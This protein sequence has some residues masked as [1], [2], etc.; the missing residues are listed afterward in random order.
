MARLPG[1]M[2]LRAV[3]AVAACLALIAVPAPGVAARLGAPAVEPHAMAE[4]ALATDAQ[5]IPDGSR[6]VPLPSGAPVQL[7]FTLAFSNQTELASLLQD[8]GDPGSA[9]YRHYLTYPEF[10]AQFGPSP[11]TTDGL[12]QYLADAGAWGVTTVAGGLGVEATLSTTEA[13][14]LLGVHFVRFAAPTGAMGTTVEGVPTLPPSLRSS[15]VGVDGLSGGTGGSLL[16]RTLTVGSVQPAYVQDGSFGPDWYLGSDFTQAYGAISLLPGNRTSVPNAV[17]PYRVA[18]ATLLA[19]G[20]NATTA[21]TLPPFDPSVLNDYFNATFPSAWPHPNVTGVPVQPLGTPMPPL[22]GS[23]GGQNDSTGFEIEN[24]LDLEMAGSL[25]PGAALYNF[26]FSGELAENPATWSNLPAYLTD[27]FTSALAY[28]YSPA[29]LAVISCSFG[30]DDLNFSLW[31][32]DLS[33]AAAMGVTVV[34]SSGDQGNA[35]SQLTGRSQDPWPLW[36]ASAAFSTSG[37]VAVGG[38]SLELSGT[39]TETYVSGPL[40]LSYDPD[41]DGIANSSAW[42]DTSG[43]PGDYAGTEGGVSSVY[44][45]PT[46]QFHSAAQPEI[47]NAAE[48]EGATALGRAEPDVAFP[49]NSTIAFVAAAANETPYYTVLAGT[50]VAAP[51]LA[52]LLADVVAVE[53][54][55]GLRFGLGYLDPVLYNIS[56]YYQANPTSLSSPFVPVDFGSNFV[57]SAGPGWNPT[58]GWGGLNAPLFLLADENASIAGYRY[59]GPTPLLPGTTPTPTSPETLLVVLAA[60]VLVVVAAA[61]VLARRARPGPAAGAAVRGYSA[62][63]SKPGSPAPYATFACPSC[64]ADR[65]AEPGHCPHCGAM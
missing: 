49:A 2:V 8:V 22:P 34:A 44:P 35:P 51:V 27:D 48:L 17:F 12:E 13:G 38:V 25:A 43:G 52:G 65:P 3:I 45:E 19:S 15:V 56:S 41:V 7:T 20:Y 16:A 60:A 47:V 10:M 29:R 55:S 42:W 46:W 61:A 1:G 37:A 53:Q 5:T 4:T 18:V 31:D 11:A 54:A 39:A 57:F 24:S 33:V 21:T 14:A 64:G 63:G 30:E 36:P 58:D 9:L 50:S 26:Y 32:A 62:G 40:K 59:T 23:F 6:V 28:N